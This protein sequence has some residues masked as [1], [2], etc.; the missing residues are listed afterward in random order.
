MVEPCDFAVE[1]G[2]I[3][4]RKLGLHFRDRVG[5]LG[6]VQIFQ[7][8]RNIGQHGEITGYLARPPSTMIFCFVAPVVTV[9]IPGLI[10]A[11]TGACPASTPKSPSR[12][13]ISTW[14]TSPEKASFSGETRS[15]WKVAMLNLAECGWRIAS[16]ERSNE[17]LIAIS[18]SPFALRL[19]RPRASCPFRPPLRW[20][21]PCRRRPPAGDRIYPRTVRENP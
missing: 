11:T 8:G 13:G 14:S 5:E 1:L 7:R 16:D 12:P 3:L 17:H 4:F 20:C 21:R 2:A 9:R 15:K 18:R 19:L 6:A 10:A